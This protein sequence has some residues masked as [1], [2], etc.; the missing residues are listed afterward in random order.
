MCHEVKERQDVVIDL[1]AWLSTAKHVRLND[2]RKERDDKAP[3]AKIFSRRLEPCDRWYLKFFLFFS[4]LRKSSQK[5]CHLHTVIQT[6]LLILILFL[7]FIIGSLGEAGMASQCKD[8][9]MSFVHFLCGLENDYMVFSKFLLLQ[10]TW[11]R[12]ITLWAEQISDV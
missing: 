11:S 10:L 1:E 7:Y 6:E 5:D 8:L 2:T 4:L 9:K 3:W 12:R